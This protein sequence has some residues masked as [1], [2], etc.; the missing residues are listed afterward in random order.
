MRRLLGLFVLAVGLVAAGCAAAPAATGGAAHPDVAAPP[1]TT[2]APEPTRVRIPAIDADSTLIRTGMM[3]DG[4]P[5]VPDVHQPLQASWA[6]WSPEPGQPGPAVLYGHV[7]GEIG[8]RKGQPGIFHRIDDLRPGDEVLVDRE[9]APTARFVVDQIVAFP[10][11]ELDDPGGM[12]T[13]TVYGDTPGPELRLVTCGGAFDAAARS[14]RDQIVVFA[15][16][17]GEAT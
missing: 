2:A 16:L 17:D 7:D 13:A 12:A 15:H 1:V 6:T 14:Y 3:P 10:K 8:G 4:S 11:V 9:N 5:E